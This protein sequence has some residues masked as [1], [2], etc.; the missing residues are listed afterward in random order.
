[1]REYNI[2]YMPL[3]WPYTYYRTPEALMFRTPQ[4]PEPTEADATIFVIE[5][6][7]EEDR[8]SAVI[9]RELVGHHWH[10]RH[11]RE[12]RDQIRAMLHRLKEL[13]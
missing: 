9:I 10:F 7:S 13:Q 4:E 8:A 12:V 1:M 6:P 3:N 2:D 11:R 5:E